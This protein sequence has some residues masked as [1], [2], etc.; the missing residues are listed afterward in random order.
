MGFQKVTKWLFSKWQLVSL[1]EGRGVASFPKCSVLIVIVLLGLAVE[2]RRGLEF[3]VDERMGQGHPA[4][5]C[6]MVG[7]QICDVCSASPSDPAPPATYGKNI[8]ASHHM[9]ESTSHV[10]P[11][12]R[13]VSDST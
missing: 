8:F 12:S 13:L 10:I 2:T 7:I 5:A 3:T 11:S 1:F 4:P 6:R 9:I